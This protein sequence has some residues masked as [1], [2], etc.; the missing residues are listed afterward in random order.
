LWIF[1]LHIL[2][3]A[4][5]GAQVLRREYDLAQLA[6]EGLQAEVTV[7]KG[8]A[9]LWESMQDSFMK[10]M[11]QGGC[12]VTGDDARRLRESLPAE[13]VVER[14]EGKTVVSPYAWSGQE[15]VPKLDVGRA[16]RFGASEAYRGLVDSLPL[17][18]AKTL[19]HLMF[20]LPRAFYRKVKGEDP[21]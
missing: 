8:K 18:E 17:P 16:A 5:E 12:V 4:D 10:I 15:G 3:K 9:A 7:A 1:S 11:E 21:Q 6:I 19:C 14:L 13:E 2:K 20:Q